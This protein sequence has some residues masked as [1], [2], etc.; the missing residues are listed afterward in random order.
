MKYKWLYIFILFSYFNLYSQINFETINPKDDLITIRTKLKR[1]SELDSAGY[2][3]EK[4]FDNFFNNYTYK[5]SITYD[6]GIDFIS[7]YVNNDKMRLAVA[8]LEMKKY[9]SAKELNKIQ[10]KYRKMLKH[11]LEK[12]H[13]KKGNY[14]NFYK[15]VDKSG[16][17]FSTIVYYL[18]YKQKMISYY[19]FFSP[20]SQFDYLRYS[21]SN[22]AIGRN[23]LHFLR[24]D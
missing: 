9:N 4:I 3:E 2:K 5:L 7:F 20:K 8:N 1:A 19:M 17:Y 23:N 18:D 21:L 16:E 13:F 24:I 10:S 14:N 15:Q 6:N 11:L 22:D 12:G